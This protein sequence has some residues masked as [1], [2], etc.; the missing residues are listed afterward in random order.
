MSENENPQVPET[1]AKGQGKYSG[2][3]IKVLEG[4]EAVRKRPSMYIG[5]TGEAGFHH[6]VSEV[7]DNSIDEAL[8]GY[9]TKIEVIINEDGS[10]SV[11]DDGRGIPVDIHPEEGIPA[12]ELVMTKLHAGGKFDKSNYKVSGGLHGVGCSCGNA[13]SAFLEEEVR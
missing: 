6:L 12:I 5:D 10:L 4:L 8:A 3:D 7:V 9:C 13:F 1:D 2:E 11:Q